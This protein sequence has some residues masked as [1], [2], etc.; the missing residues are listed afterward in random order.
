LLQAQ[1]IFLDQKYQFIIIS[2]GISFPVEPNDFEKYWDP[3]YNITLGYGFSPKENI[4]ALLDFEYYNFPFSKT[5]YLKEFSDISDSQ[6]NTNG[7]NY[8]VLSLCLKMKFELRISNSDLFP[9]IS[10]GEGWLR[11]YTKNV[12]INSNNVAL[13]L[14]GKIKDLYILLISTGLEYDLNELF[15]LILELNY[16]YGSIDNY[17]INFIP[18]KLGLVIKL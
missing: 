15:N 17:K 14:T 9:F 16:R 6:I 7:N 1:H 11:Y 13:Q 2:S 4:Y 12:I 3:G 10:I 18:I 8:E 5:K